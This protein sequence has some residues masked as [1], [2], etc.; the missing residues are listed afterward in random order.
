MIKFI[1]DNFPMFGMDFMPLRGILSG[2][3]EKTPVLQLI[4]SSRLSLMNIQY[5]VQSI[6]F[7]LF[8]DIYNIKALVLK[9]V[10]V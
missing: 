4:S 10:Y 8:W 6:K 9:T 1:L 3:E 2:K 5:K 7:P